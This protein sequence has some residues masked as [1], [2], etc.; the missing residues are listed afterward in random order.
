MVFSKSLK[1][2]F[3]LRSLKDAKTGGEGEERGGPY[4]KPTAYY[5]LS[6]KPFYPSLSKVQHHGADTCPTFFLSPSNSPALGSFLSHSP[7][8]SSL[9]LS[10]TPFPRDFPSWSNSKCS[11]LKISSASPAS[12]FFWLASLS[13]SPNN[14]TKGRVRNAS[15]V[16]EERL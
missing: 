12:S 16:L 14:T 13:L 1:T 3:L 6:K 15:K 2:F 10:Y 9:P 7:P 4:S 11:L 8:S 5:K